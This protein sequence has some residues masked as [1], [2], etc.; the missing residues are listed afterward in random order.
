[1]AETIPSDDVRD[2][3]LTSARRL[4]NGRG[5]NVT[6][7]DLLSETAGVSKRSLYQ[8]FRT[9][10]DLIEAYLAE[11]M[12]CVLADLLPPADAGLSPAGRIMAVFE[13]ARRLSEVDDYPGCPV[14]NAAAEIRD[15]AH[16]VRVAAVTYKKRMQAHFEAE[17]A[18][19]GAADPGQLGE[20]LMM[21]FDGAMT[22]ASVR[23][24]PMPASLLTAVRTLLDAQLP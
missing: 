20:Q 22:Y 21:L 13:T 7:V 1:M 15:P 16:P 18:L 24:V 6:G 3:V 9:K 4:F 12:G 14:L 11:E 2:R 23:K 5:I 10:D 19:A 17:A 8:R